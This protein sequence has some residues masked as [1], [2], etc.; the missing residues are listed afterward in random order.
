MRTGEA[1]GNNAEG[2]FANSTP[3]LERKR[4]LWVLNSNHS[5]TLK[6]LKFGRS[7]AEETLSGLMA[8]FVL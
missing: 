5:S 4:Q 6:G 2:A 8:F 7:D 3:G 1:L